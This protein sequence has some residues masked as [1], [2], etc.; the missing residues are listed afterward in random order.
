MIDYNIHSISEQIKHLLSISKSRGLALSQDKIA[1]ICRVQKSYLSK[2]LNA[3]ASFSDDQLYLLNNF[4]ELSNEEKIFMQLLLDLERSALEER[5]IFLMKEIRSIQNVKLSPKEQLVG[6]KLQHEAQELTHY[7]LNPWH[8]LIHIGFTIPEYKKQAEKLRKDLNLDKRFFDQSLD[9]LLKKNLIVFD[10]GEWRSIETHAHLDKGS[11]LYW[12][13]KQGLTQLSLEHLK[14]QVDD[15]ALSFNVVF[16]CSHKSQRKIKSL[17]LSFIKELESE[18]I[19]S[20]E[21]NLMQI[22]LDFFNWSQR[23]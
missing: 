15:D 21:E 18:V 20:K 7:Y 5:K 23:G 10:N 11:A 6:K 9:Y 2:V 22:N 17:L 14:K 1:E 12:P 4:F 3:K 19:K 8:Q 13:W 16:S